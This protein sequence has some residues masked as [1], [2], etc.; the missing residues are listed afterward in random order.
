MADSLDI[1]V[2]EDNDTLRIVTVEALCQSGHRARGVDSAEKLGLLD[3]LEAVRVFI[4]DLNLPGEDGLSLTRRLRVRM[5]RAGIIMVTAR[6]TG[7]DQVEGYQTGADIYLPKPVSTTTLLSAVDALARRLESGGR[8]LQRAVLDEL[9]P[10]L[11]EIAE[12]LADSGLSYKE[13]AVR[14]EVGEGTIRRHVERLYRRLG[15]SSRAEL[16]SRLRAP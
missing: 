6:T 16:S 11:R 7:Q 14:L 4:I 9:P 10:R 8:P 5:P 2:V 15:V 3:R 12:L 1:V 13:I